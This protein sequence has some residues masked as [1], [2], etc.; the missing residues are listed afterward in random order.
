MQNLAN[1][2]FLNLMSPARRSSQIKNKPGKKLIKKD[3]FDKAGAG[4]S[5][6]SVV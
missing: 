1:S 4:E 2:K 3:A 5:R 6:I